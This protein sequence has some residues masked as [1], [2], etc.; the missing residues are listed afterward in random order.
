MKRLSLSRRAVLT[1]VAGTAIALPWLEA[2]E[3]RRASAAAAATP[4]RFIALMTCGGIFPER[5]WPTIAGETPYPLDQP[6]RPY[7]LGGMPAG[8]TTEDVACLTIKALDTRD[9]VMSPSLAPLSRHKDDLLLIEGIDSAGG[10]GHDQWPCMLTGRKGGGGISLDQEI[11]NYIAGNTKFKSLQL[12][13]HDEANSDR[14]PSWYDAGMAALAESNPQT[15]FDRVFAEVGAPDTTAIDRLRAQRKSVLDAA[16]SQIAELQKQ[17]GRDDRAK[18]QNYADS[19]R[20]VESRLNN[21]ASGASCARPKI[22][23]LTTDRWWW[24]TANTPLVTTTQLDILA[25]AFAC[26]LTRVATVTIGNNNSSMTLPWLGVTD[27]FH[28]SL[29]HA[30]D[31]NMDAQNKIAKIDNWN[32]EQLAGLVDRLKAIPEG[33]GTVF[34]NTVI[35]WVQELTKGNTHNVD[36]MPHIVLG[37][38]GGFL[39]TGRYLRLPRSGAKRSPFPLGRWSNDFNVTMLQSMGIPA[40]T[41]GDPTQFTAPLD[42]LK[43]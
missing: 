38:A 35:M 34:D 25:M 15:V 19:I 27:S 5:F 7:F 21:A 3:P 2:M 20:E 36:N 37:S 42:I 29:G 31:S 33:N 30:V 16:S 8:C 40:T 13:V 12:G 26:D 23:T 10:S 11:A 39:K 9:Y 17:L 6:P 28:D 4:K 41:F 18:L 43:A 24:D 22:N 1:G 14:G 32:A